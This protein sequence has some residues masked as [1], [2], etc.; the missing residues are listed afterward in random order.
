MAFKIA[1]GQAFKKAAL[2]AKPVIL[3][4]VVSLKVTVP[5]ANMGEVMGDLNS[6]KRGRV[7]GME[8]IGNGF[9]IIEAQAP[10]SEVQRY[11]TDLRSMTQGRGIFI[12]EMSHY[13]PVPANVAD[14]IIEANKKEETAVAAHH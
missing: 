7:L 11:A 14:R 8:Q 3:E 2:S 6:N 1:A 10:M 5:D 9:T 12:M 13:E 4:P